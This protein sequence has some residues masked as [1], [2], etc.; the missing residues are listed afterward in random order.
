MGGSCPTGGDAAPALPTLPALP[1]TQGAGGSGAAL[2]EGHKGKGNLAPF[3]PEGPTQ[4][5]QH[6][7]WPRGDR[8]A[9]QGHSTS[10]ASRLPQTGLSH[11]NTCQ[12]PQHRAV[13]PCPRLFPGLPWPH[14]RT[15]SSLWC[16]GGLGL[17][18]CRSHPGDPD[19]R[20]AG[21]RTWGG[22]TVLPLC[23]QAPS[24]PGRQRVKG[25]KEGFISYF[26]AFPVCEAPL[27]FNLRE[28]GPLCYPLGAADEEPRKG[29]GLPLATRGCTLS[30]GSVWHMWSPCSKA[31]QTTLGL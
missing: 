25:Q 31:Q 13:G 20:V 5:T 1:A 17:A 21:D 8:I 26:V 10:Q 19:L 15:P 12:P 3:L 23:S 29:T 7:T 24:G 11:V 28:P 2:G 16:A 6:N 9:P 4:V 27:Y 22:L 30:P 14:P 18:A